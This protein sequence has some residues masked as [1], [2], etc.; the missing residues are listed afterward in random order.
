M[1]RNKKMTILS[2]L[3]ALVVLMIV[4]G[5]WWYVFFGQPNPPLPRVNISIASSSSPG[6]VSAAGVA[7]TGTATTAPK[8]VV[9][10]DSDSSTDTSIANPPLETESLAIDSARFSV[11]VAS[12]AVEQARG[13]SY[14]ASLGENDGMLFIFGAGAVQT[15]WMKDMRFPL[16]MIWISGNVVAGFTQNIPTPAPGTQLWQLPV[17]TSPVNTDKVLEVNAG[18]VAKYNIKAGDTVTIGGAG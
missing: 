4:V 18:T 14:R 3:A 1:V 12:T 15:F 17:Y 10:A 6:V 9:A 2:I 8:N 13:L 16:D 5:V 7:V 11:E